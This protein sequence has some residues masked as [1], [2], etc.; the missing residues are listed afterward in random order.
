MDS[1][2]YFL[3]G[4]TL[5]S[6]RMPEASVMSVKRNEGAVCD[7]AAGSSAVFSGSAIPPARIRKTRN[8]N[9]T[10]INPLLEYNEMRRLYVAVLGIC[11]SLRKLAERP[12]DTPTVRRDEDLTNAAG[13]TIPHL[14]PPK[15]RYTVE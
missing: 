13:L 4:E 9:R 8:A 10:G 5:C 3:S 6:K 12:A 7:L 14:S 1:T 2:R 11:L 15:K